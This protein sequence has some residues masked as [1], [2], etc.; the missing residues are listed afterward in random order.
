MGF[1]KVKK[2]KHS[3]TGYASENERGIGAPYFL[4]L[5][6]MTLEATPLSL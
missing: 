4:V 2:Q 3:P 1:V 5:L 6:T